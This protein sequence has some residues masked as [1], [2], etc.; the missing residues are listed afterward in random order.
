MNK[1]LLILFSVSFL[2]YSQAQTLEQGENQSTATWVQMMQ[3]PN[4]NFYD[5]QAAFYS[6][7]EGKTIEKGKGYKVFKRWEHYMEPRVYPTGN[8]KLPSQTYENYKLWERDAEIRTEKSLSG[9]WSF[10]GPIGK[11]VGGGAGRLN[12]VRFDPNNINTIYVGAPDGGLWKSTDNAVSWSTNTD[13]LAVIGCSDLAINPTNSQILY[14][15]TG[16][17]EAS[18]SYSVGVL[19]STDGGTT[20]NTTGLTWTASQGRTIS[21][22]LIDPSNPNMLLAATS[23][24]LWR[25]IDAGVTWTSVNTGP[26]ND[27]EFK[28]GDSNTIYATGSSLRKSTNNGANWTTISSGLPSS[29]VERISI[30]VTA[31]NASYV[32]L[33]YG[34]SSDQGLLGIY[35]STDSGT[36]FTQRADGSPNYLGWNSDGSDSGGQAF[37]DLTIAASPT[38]AEQVLIGGVNT[39]KSTNGGQNFTIMSHWTGSGAPYAHA[40]H[41]DIQY[42]NG[43][44]IYDANDGGLFKSTNTGTSWSDVSA[45]LVIAQQY[46]IGTS[47]STQNLIIAGHQDN[48]TNRLNG[49][50]WTQV[51]GGDGM[52]CFIDR[53]NNSI[54]VGS[55]VYGDYYKSTNGGSSFSD[56]TNGLPVGQ[57]SAEWLSV[58][59]QDP[60]TANTYYAGGRSALYRTTNGGS[61]W[62]ALG[63]PTGSGSVVEFAI[64]P[65]NNQVIYAIKNNSISKSTD[66]GTN[67]T[68]ITAGLPISGLLLTNVAVSNTDAN[69]VYVTFSGYNVAN[70]VFKST[71]GG[72]SWSNITSGL[73]N[74]PCN[75]IVYHNSS[76]NDAVYVGTDVGVFYKDNNLASWTM[77][78]TNLPRVAVRDLEIFYP[79]GRLRAGTYGRGTW[80]SDL[81][82]NATLPVAGFTANSQVVCG[83]QTVTFTNTTGGG[84]TSYEWSFTGGTPST[85]TAINPTITYNIPGMYAVQLIA[86]N[87][88]GSDTLLQTNYITVTEGQAL[89]FNEGFTA[90]GFPYANWTVSDLQINGTWLRTLEAGNNPT[91][92]DAVLFDNYGIDDRGFNDEF[93]IPNLNLSTTTDA[94]LSFDVAYAPYDAVN[95]DSLEVLISTDCGQSYTSIYLKGNT[96]LA[97]A[98]STTASFTPASNQWRTESVDLTPYVSASNVEIVFRNI[99]G[100]GN[101][102]FLDNLNIVGTP[103]TPP[104]AS[105]TQTSN[106]ICPTQTVSYTNTSLDNPTMYQWTFEGG[107]PATSSLQNPVVTYNS[108]GT[109]DVELIVTNGFGSD[110]LTL[111]NQINVNVAPAIPTITASGPLT[112]CQGGSVTLTSS[113]AAGNTWSNTETTQSI[114]VSTAGSYTVTNTNGTCESSS[115]AT[116]VIVNPI[117]NAPVISASGATT[118]C[119]GGSV[120]LTSS[121][122]TG[123]T[124]STGPTTQQITV[125]TTTS[126]ISTT[127]TASGCTSPPS[128]VINVTVNPLPVVTFDNLA[129]ICDT[130][131]PLLLNTGTPVGGSYSGLGVISG[132]FDPGIVSLGAHTITY[133]FTNAN[134]CIGNDQATI[135]VVSCEGSGV[136]EAILNGFIIFPNPTQDF[137]YLKGEKLSSYTTIEIINL[138]GKVVKSI[139]IDASEM[140]VSVEGLASGSYNVRISNADKEVIQKIQVI[141]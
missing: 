111:I 52:D 141:K 54:M 117:P 51:Y 113:S 132:S 128:N 29:N 80:D 127:T 118:F 86:I 27:I 1:V 46:R 13:Q 49:A 138:D 74:V 44:T 98:A 134:N 40:D 58:I 32:Y 85:S 34:Q 22:L 50:T 17:G 140:K 68:S 61:S 9:D 135:T 76:A 37:Y 139:K 53:T 104:T 107:T 109:F 31:A 72:T 75:T 2:A 102:L 23:A 112:F 115:T 122:A 70:K 25:T 96:D 108:A 88:I 55:Y 93:K 82:T 6:Y 18:D 119:Q 97:T 126:N 137:I 110:T 130:A 106:T 38:N 16:D 131:S 77:Y 103:G 83:G 133:T 99:A 129:S 64:A 12:F 48:G 5:I 78:S 3:D 73:P 14:L 136:E 69:V 95:Y 11:P 39:W 19:K 65:S 4:A 92:N 57:G 20:W 66:G 35:R 28:P 94:T 30:A 8:I 105:F 121:V 60:V 67:W 87:G 33:L 124:W 79:T 47:A 116:T 10:L 43:T 7:W 89:P 84:A 21:K 59:H 56:I 125:N 45:N 114:V 120:T 123:N 15:A 91:P 62:S 36:T 26:Y 41:H 101:R 63:T 42:L 71:S 81:Y 90:A 100:Y 24:G